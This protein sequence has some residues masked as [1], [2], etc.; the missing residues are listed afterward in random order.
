MQE[1]INRIIESLL[2]VSGEI[3]K[4]A[5]EQSPARGAIVRAL[6]RSVEAKLWLHQS[7]AIFD[8]IK[9]QDEEKAKTEVPVE[10]TPVETTEPVEN[11]SN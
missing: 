10:E 11:E 2:L 1:K 4:L 3:E 7:L 5:L 6:E 8:D 9:R